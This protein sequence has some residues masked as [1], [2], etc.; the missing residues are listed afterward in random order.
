MVPE[1]GEGIIDNVDPAKGV[2]TGWKVSEK[3]VSVEHNVLLYPYYPEYAG[4]FY[5]ADASPASN[6]GG[7]ATGT[8]GSMARFTVYDNFL[9]AIDKYMLRLFNIT[10]GGNPQKQGE[11]YV[12]WNIETLFPYNDKLFVGSTTGMYI[13][14]LTDPSNPQFIST[15]WHA[16]GCDPVVVE[17]NL[18]YVTLRAG[19]LCGNNLSQLD[20]IDISDITTPKLLKEYSMEEPYG[21]GVDNHI[22]FIC[23]GE[24][25][26]K[27]YDASDPLVIDD[28][29]IVQ[30]SGINAW[31]VIPLGEVLLMIGTDGLYQYDYSDLQHIK[32]ISVIPIEHL[33]HG[34]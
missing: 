18:A 22:L 7:S 33:T 14:S 34:E 16:T 20:V 31:D 23:D 21:L 8:G 13:Y 3:T 30:Y 5:K 25:G 10:D 2:V 9:Y 26:L 29:K 4:A 6:G 11:F 15:F 12:G 32:Q 1:C 17:D 28:H 27:I 19:N 24:A